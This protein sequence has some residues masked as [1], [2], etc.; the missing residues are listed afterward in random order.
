MRH[1]VTW[2]GWLVFALMLAGFGLLA[3]LLAELAQ[4]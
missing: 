2:L 4:V 1:R 3:W